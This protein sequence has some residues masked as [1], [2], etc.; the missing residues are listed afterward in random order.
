MYIQSEQYRFEQTVPSGGAPASFLLG[1]HV[2]Y[3][4]ILQS[5]HICLLALYYFM[6]ETS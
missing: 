4:P 5:L 3:G 2:H 6:V 1:C